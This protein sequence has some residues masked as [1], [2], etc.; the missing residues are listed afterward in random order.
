MLGV[1]LKLASASVVRCSV[2]GF[3]LPAGIAPELGA[4]KIRA[5]RAALTMSVLSAMPSS[6]P[7]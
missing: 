7:S 4:L 3:P 2:F 5:S 1:S 6:I